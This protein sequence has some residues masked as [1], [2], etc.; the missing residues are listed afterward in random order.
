MISRHPPLSSRCLLP[1]SGR[2]WRKPPGVNR[3]PASM[4]GRSTPTGLRVPSLYLCLGWRCWPPPR[5]LP[6]RTPRWTGIAASMVPVPQSRRGP[7]LT[8]LA[9]PHLLRRLLSP[10][11]KDTSPW[12][13]T[14]CILFIS[15][16]PPRTLRA[17]SGFRSPQFPNKIRLA[18]GSVVAKERRENLQQRGW[19]ST[20]R[21]AGLFL[22]IRARL[23]LLRL[24][25]VEPCAQ[26]LHGEK[27]IFFTKSA[28]GVA[29]A[30]T[31]PLQ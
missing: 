16:K 25:R 19:R 17:V 12:A 27:N 22:L 14:G 28:S 7:R 11:W 21:R 5:N 26:L 23:G 30:A 2:R 18:Y 3:P 10:Q 20:S 6:H 29:S 4:C 1:R 13:S 24:H 15:S 31:R 8:A 9:H